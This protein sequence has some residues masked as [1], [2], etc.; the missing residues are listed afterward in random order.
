MINLQRLKNINQDHTNDGLR[1]V[2]DYILNKIQRDKSEFSRYS[3]EEDW[4]ELDQYINTIRKRKSSRELATIKQ[5][6][7]DLSESDDEL[8]EG[9]SFEKTLIRH[10]NT[11]RV[12]KD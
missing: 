9:N 4:S 3:Y 2:V 10:L 12:H 5:I 8:I 7:T 11:S 6:A 1:F